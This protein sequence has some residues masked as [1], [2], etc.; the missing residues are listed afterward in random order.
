M[1]KAFMVG[2]TWCRVSCKGRKDRPLVRQTS[3]SDNFL[4]KKRKKLINKFQKSLFTI[5]HT[6]C[7]W[8]VFEENRDL[9]L[10]PGKFMYMGSSTEIASVK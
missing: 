5:S 4:P 7:F 10:D 2:P 3:L 1:L 8:Q 9:N 6:G